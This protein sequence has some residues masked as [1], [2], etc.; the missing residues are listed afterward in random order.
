MLAEGNTQSIAT[1]ITVLC[2]GTYNSVNT[3]KLLGQEATE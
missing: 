3:D 2:C 1:E